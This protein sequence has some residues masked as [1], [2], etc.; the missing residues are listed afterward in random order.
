[1]PEKRRATSS[2]PTLTMSEPEIHLFPDD[3]SNFPMNHSIDYYD[4]LDS[5]VPPDTSYNVPHLS[6]VANCSEF[7]LFN[8]CFKFCKRLLNLLRI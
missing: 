8:N 5:L 7:R 6:D 4:L 2:S 3:L 1:M